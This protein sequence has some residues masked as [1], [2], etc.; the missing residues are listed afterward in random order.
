MSR[1]TKLG[2]IVVAACLLPLPAGATSVEF[3]PFI[4]V[5]GG[6]D[7]EAGSPDL[8]FDEDSNFGI[9]VGFPII[10]ADQ[11]EFMYSEYESSLRT[12]GSPK[13]TTAVVDFR[14]LHVGAHWER[15]DGPGKL[16][17]VASAGVVDLDAQ[18]GPYGS[19]TLLSIGLGG[20]GKYF[21]HDYFGVRAEGRILGNY[22]DGNRE[23]LCDAT[24]GCL[25]EINGS[26]LWQ[27]QASAGIVIRF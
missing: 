14:Y 9:T 2:W 20:G 23:I 18:S 3:G 5:L 17:S 6:G 7:L 22:I 15:G 26:F 16:F 27:F 13:T 11:L 12:K 10:G 4:G 24:L 1:K 25:G 19:E 8:E 21:F